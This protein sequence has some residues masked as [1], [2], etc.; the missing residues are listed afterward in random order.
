MTDVLTT[1]DDLLARRI[2]VLDGAMGTMIQRHTLTE[3]DFRGD[4]FA[5][6][7]HDLKGDN[8]LLV[9]T[10]PDVIDGIHRQYLDAGADIIE[11]NTFNGTAIS[12][13]DYGLEALA[14][15]LNVAGAR[16]A[17]Q[18]CAAATARTP[19]RPRFA[20]GSM[21]PTNRTLSISPDVNNPAFRAL[22]FDA[23]CAAYRDQARGLIDGGCDLLLLETIFDTLNAKA[24]IVAIEE[25]FEL[26]GVRLPLMISVT[27]TDRSGRTLSGQT[28][29]AFW[30]SIAHARPFSVGI[31]CALG[32]RDMRP[33]LAE[34]ARI[35]GCWVTCYPNA[36]LPNAF[37]EYDEQP[38][39]TGDYLREFATSGFV[40]IV[41]GCCGTTPE[42]I[43]A[44][45]K[46]VAGLP[47]R[48]INHGGHRGHGENIGRNVQDSSSVTSVS[49]VVDH[50]SS[51]SGLETLTIRPDSNFQMIGERTNVTGSAR[52]ARLIR[53]GNYAE[54]THVALEQ[55]RGG[56]N[57]IDVN[58]DEGMLD[59]ELAMTTFLDYIATEPEIARVPVMIDSSKWSVLLAGLKCVQGKPIVNSISLKEGEDEFLKKAAT[60]RRYGAGAVVM[61][62]DETGQADT[63]ERKVAI[64]Q[65]AY[66]LLT[67]RAGF[68]PSDIIFDPNILAIA[69][70]LEEHNA[71]AINFIEA[72]RII[73]ATCP[74][75]KVSGGIS[76]LSF[77]FR[78]NDIVR[79][80]IHSAFLYHAIAAGLDMGIVNAG[81]LVVYEDIPKDLLT[82]VEDIIF[83]RRPDATERMVEFAATV[84]GDGKK[85][86]LDLAW[87][88]HPVETRLSHALV[89]GVV[90]FIE[91]DV[92]EAR[93]KYPRPLDIIEGP[94]MDGMKVVGDLFGAGKMF[95][96]QVVKSARAMK[97]A[98]AYLEPFMKAEREARM[99]AGGAVETASKGT[100]VLAT[101][102]GDV[103]DI[104]KN[105]V[106]VVLGCNSYH[107]ID[108]G[109]MVPCDRILQ[110]ALDAKADLI[111]VSGL[112]TP[113]LDEMVMVAREMERRHITLPLLIGGATTS[114]QHTAVKVAPEYSQTTVHVLDASRVV[115]V[116]SSLLSGERRAAFE[117]TTREQQ[118]H[119]RDQYTARRERPLLPYDAAL[120]NRLAIDW[121]HE[122]L[123]QPAFIGRRVL[124]D[125]PLADLV[126]W[127]DWTFFFA[128]WELKGRFPAI[129]DH[130]QYGPAARDLYDNARRLLDRIVGEKLLT[131][132]GVYGFW[133]AVSEDDDIVV[134]RDRAHSGELARFNLLR[135]QET[136]A[137]GQSNLSLADFIAPR[138][139]TGGSD[140]LGAFAVTAGIG[141]DDLARRFEREQ[142]DYSAIL[143]KA[144]AD[145]L[146]EAFATYLHKTARQDWGV[147]DGSATTDI[148]ISEQHQ[149]IRP[150]FGYPA[151]PDHSEKFK[152]FDLLGARELGIDLTDH[153]AMTPAASVSGLYFAHPKARYFTVGRL[154]DDQVT[155]YARRK[156]Q[157]VEQVE[158]W[159]SPNLAYEPARA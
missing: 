79:E 8:D 48:Q 136:M 147:N 6:H 13:A 59:S 102:K 43:A 95:L 77:S 70:G 143:V 57:L 107:V 138:K 5:R 52:F 2:L 23:L 72:T 28:V 92:E 34:L 71:Y 85:R 158:R 141:A 16:L 132:R 144:L 29:D 30:T 159:L 81:Q 134:Y 67:E 93:L 148:I 105:I 133:P 100:I 122:S 63:I 42:H 128:A 94:L 124:P 80:A 98:V 151:C 14:Y 37:G 123:P 20:A 49:S 44:I 155:A 125:V 129:L 7:A 156:G 19:D 154:G 32:A 146:V 58:M 99:A 150:A 120:K 66:R 9:L 27:I 139:G 12:Q 11:T 4:R 46:A 97:R 149:G 86:E 64:C 38:R 113:S 36:G 21:G 103:H 65:R 117:Q 51:F 131:A 140:H 1:L 130:P 104:G 78:G 62:F 39:D 22:T 26:T 91:A 47:P 121:T 110:T 142:D 17:K 109:V 31:N 3:A 157:S 126:P 90:D 25:A 73:K 55:V 10:R 15:E 83:N 75:V 89:H 56:A 61:A 112:I 101:V 106:G 152:L 87:R 115:D 76:N 116:V 84:K 88:D 82:H 33:Y 50:Y 24:G 119:L 108:L 68:D 45:A 69:T 53:A 74:G 137:A 60:V 54:A 35:A 135:Q 41:G 96:P 18:A 40:N 118:Q 127:I 153:A 111:G 145:R 114:K